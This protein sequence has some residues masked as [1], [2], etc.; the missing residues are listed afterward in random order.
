M[1]KE[2]VQRST[3]C[4]KDGLK[5][6]VIVKKSLKIDRTSAVRIAAKRE[7]L[8]IQL[9]QEDASLASYFES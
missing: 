2:K 1:R 7:E 3:F 9:L 5:E 4:S 6:N 8:H